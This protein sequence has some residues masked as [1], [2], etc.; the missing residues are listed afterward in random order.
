MQD[1]WERRIENGAVL[2]RARQ[3]S[4]RRARA[5]LP[6]A[7]RH[8]R[9]HHDNGIRRHSR[10]KRGI[11]EMRRLYRS[12]LAGFA[13]PALHL[14]KTVMS[15]LGITHLAPGDRFKA[16]AVLAGAVS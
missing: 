7:G 6:C 3:A 8:T 2:R 16:I 5:G 9:P 14:E 1:E 12:C 11:R 10:W 4:C 15:V 13:F